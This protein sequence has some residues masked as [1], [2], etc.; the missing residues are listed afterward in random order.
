MTNLEGRPSPI[1]AIVGPTAVGKSQ[2]GIE[3]AL[4]LC[5]EI[6]SADSRQVYIGMDIG[7]AKPTA[8]DLEKV[9][10]HLIN[11]RR[12]DE[13]M[14]LAEYQSLAYTAIHQVQE[15]GRVP[16]L[17]GGTGQYV[18]SIVQ[19][20]SIPG[21]APNSDLRKRLE[22]R[23]S[24]MGHAELHRELAAVDPNAARTIDSRNVRRVIRAL[25]VF[26]LT[27]HTI[28]ELKRRQTRPSRVIQIG[29]TMPRTEL[30]QRIDSRIDGMLR[31]GLIDEVNN[32]LAS[33]Y[34][35]S[36]PSM[37][38]VGYKQIASFLQNEVTLVD[39]I[40]SMKRD[41]RILARH[42]YNWFKPADPGIMWLDVASTTQSEM[43]EKIRQ[44]LDVDGQTRA[45][46][47]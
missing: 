37:S 12:P 42:Q 45:G 2:L 23:A 47:A 20:W 44:R 17:V 36:L 7:T 9:P 1:V 34:G 11:I 15:R 8:T 25:E 26:Q 31:L 13:S 5:G 41:T 33:G 28:T 18:K 30:Y 10:H 32:L 6:V 35:K 24:E 19:G 40:M 29:L 22:L 39:A 16:I 3:L 21:V 43:L 38:S 4:V 27:G 46:L 14:T